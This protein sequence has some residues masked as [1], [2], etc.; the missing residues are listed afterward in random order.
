MLDS[1]IQSI[2]QME[3]YYTYRLKFTMRDSSNH[4]VHHNYLMETENECRNILISYQERAWIILHATI[5]VYI[6]GRYSHLITIVYL[7]E[8]KR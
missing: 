8:D 3:D 1:L 5:D 6:N 4:Y 2:Y 7:N